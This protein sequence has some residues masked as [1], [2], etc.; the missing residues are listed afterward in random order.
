MRWRAS[1]TLPKL[2][3]PITLRKWKSLGLAEGLEDGPRLICWDGLGCEGGSE[4]RKGWRRQK[5]SKNSRMYGKFIKGGCA[6]ISLLHSLLDANILT[7]GEGFAFMSSASWGGLKFRI[8][9]TSGLK[10]KKQRANSLNR[11]TKDKVTQPPVVYTQITG[12]SAC[13]FDAL[14]FTDNNTMT[15][16][17]WYS[18]LAGVGVCGKPLNEVV[19]THS[20]LFHKSCNTQGN[21]EKKKIKILTW[22]NKTGHP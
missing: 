18:L 19:Q 16:V 10:E 6:C 14:S 1:K 13:V 9:W 3:L 22:K 11:I 17:R 8:D 2:P 5:H 7:G 21:T 12:I 20:P 4:V 15:W